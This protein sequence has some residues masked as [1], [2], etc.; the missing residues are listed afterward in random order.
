MKAYLELA[1][2][3]HTGLLPTPAHFLLALPLVAKYQSDGLKAL[4]CRMVTAAF[5]SSPAAGA[6]PHD[7]SA[8]GWCDVLVKFEQ[9]F[10]PPGGGWTDDVV[11]ELIAHTMGYHREAGMPVA[12][13]RNT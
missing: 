3:A 5:A 6:R 9:L 1:S 2:I 4:C 12:V 13:P 10:G 8:P 11:G 7:A